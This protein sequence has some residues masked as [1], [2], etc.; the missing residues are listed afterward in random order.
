V[1]TLDFI[2]QSGALGYA[3]LFGPG[4]VLLLIALA[5][6]GAVKTTHNFVISGRLLGFGFGVA[7]LISVWTWSM[8]VMLSSAQAY[9]W[10]S[11][12]SSGS[13]CPTGLR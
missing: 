6:K 12:D 3:L 7:S 9:T 13:S 11:P 8:A 1:P 10:G 2:Q 4:I 5:V